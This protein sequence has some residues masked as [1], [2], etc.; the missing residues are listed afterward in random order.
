MKKKPVCRSSNRWVCVTCNSKSMT[1][2][3]MKSHL[4][5]DHGISGDLKGSRQ[6]L[7]HIDGRDFFASDY[8]WVFETNKGEVNA[9]QKTVTPRAKRRPDALCLT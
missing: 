5:S 4:D 3:K 1:Q 7:I 6:M 9:V 8:N 2:N